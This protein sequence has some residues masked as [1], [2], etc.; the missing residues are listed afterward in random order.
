MTHMP[1]EIVLAQIM[2]SLDL[3]FERALHF[4]DEG[5]ESDNDNGLPVQVMRPVC[6]YQSSPLRPPSTLLATREHN[7]P[8]L[9]AQMTQG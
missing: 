5:Y 3:K 7:V 1:D 9:H 6:I 4:H 8:S 2:T